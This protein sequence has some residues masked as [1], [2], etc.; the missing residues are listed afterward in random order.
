V[1]YDEKLAARIRELIAGEHGVTERRMFGG[2][3]FLVGGNM[4]ITASGRGGALV[5][6]DPAES[7]VLVANTAA[8][9]FEMRGRQMQGWL[10]VSSDDLQPTRELQQWV[11]VGVAYARTLPP[12]R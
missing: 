5:R 9:R 2:L 6:C 8:T 11:D 3:A 12:K 7:S 10:R 1:A 4:A